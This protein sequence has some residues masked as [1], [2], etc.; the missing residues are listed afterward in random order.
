MD[1]P[2]VDSRCMSSFVSACAPAQCV[3]GQAHW[4]TPLLPRRLHKVVMGNVVATPE[5][6]NAPVVRSAVGIGPAR[7]LAWLPEH[8]QDP[9]LDS[10]RYTT[11]RS[12][13]E[14][15]Y[16]DIFRGCEGSE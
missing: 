6:P 1:T 15:H 7:S 12:D 8:Y 14:A 9:Y 10:L 3:K 5:W 16:I 11:L 2:S 4:H 13:S